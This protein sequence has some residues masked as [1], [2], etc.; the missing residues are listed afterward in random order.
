MIL[1]TRIEFSMITSRGESGAGPVISDSKAR[2]AG[3]GSSAELLDEKMIPSALVR[4]L[5]RAANLRDHPAHRRPDHMGAVEPE[6]IEERC[7]VVSH[8]LERVDRRAGPPEIRAHQVGHQAT[9]GA[10]AV[11]FGGQP[12][13]T[14]VVADHPVALVDQFLAETV[15]PQQKLGRAP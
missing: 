7:G 3:G 5:C 4:R 11:Q 14:V 13:V 2:G 6:M 9:T 10:L 1:P 12:H 8:V 15:T